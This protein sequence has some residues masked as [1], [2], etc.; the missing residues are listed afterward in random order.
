MTEI[1]HLQRCVVVVSAA[2]VAYFEMKRRKEEALASRY[3]VNKITQRNDAFAIA[4]SDPQF[5]IGWFHRNL[6][7]DY[8]S[9]TRIASEIEQKWVT[10]G[11]P[12]PS[13]HSGMNVMGQVAVTLKYLTSKETFHEVG[14]LF[15][16]SE[17]TAN[18]YYSRVS[19]V[20]LCMCSSVIVF[21]QTDYA[22]QTVTD[23]F[24]TSRGFPSVAGVIDG[25]LVRIPR[26]VEYD[27]YYCRKQF[28]ALNIQAVADH[29]ISFMHIAIKP[30][31]YNDAM[32]WKESKE[33]ILPHIPRGNHIL[34]DSGYAIESRLLI[35][36][37]QETSDSEPSAR[38][39]N[40]I[41]C[42]TRAIIEQTFGLWKQRFAKLRGVLPFSC[43]HKNDNL[44][45]CCAVL[46][47]LLI[48]YYDGYNSDMLAEYAELEP[49]DNADDNLVRNAP[50]QSVDVDRR[51]AK[52]HA[53]RKRDLIKE[54]LRLQA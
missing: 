28:P 43:P 46:H 33:S 31:C 21:P 15:G 6:R 7:C 24:E 16:I 11:I 13:V 44:I 47:N 10:L 8:R 5:H 54:V 40:R 19:S 1:D 51:I 23:G 22:W 38:Y 36:Y 50:E 39:F 32:I 12:L 53:E 18:T 30:G 17:S 2:L 45:I 48:K 29:K 27:G 35:P 49:E 37:D 20:L 34:G 26:P 9:L 3:P 14:I 52:L 25:C 4:C 41:F 42:G